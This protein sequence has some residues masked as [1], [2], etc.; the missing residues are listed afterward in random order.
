VSAPPASPKQATIL[1]VDDNDA[2]RLLAQSTLEDEDYRVVLAR[3][4]QEALETFDREQPDC[5]L[6]DAAMPDLDGFAVCTRIRASPRNADTPIVFLTAHRDLETFDRAIAAGADDF[7]TKPARPTELILRVAAAVRIRRMRTELDEH[8]VA[9][10]RQRDDLLRLHLQKERLI[11]FVVHDLKNPV[12]ALDLHAQVLLSKNLP[13]EVSSSLRAI[14]DNARQLNRMILGLLDLS[15]GDEGRLVVARTRVSSSRLV[16][17]VF[18]ELHPSAEQ[19]HIELVSELSVDHLDVDAS[20]F[21]RLL[22]NLVDNAIR[23]APRASSVQVKVGRD[24]LGVVLDVMDSGS[25]IEADQ[26]QSIF[27]AFAQADE[28]THVASRVGHGLG[29]TFCKLVAEAHGGRISVADQVDP[30]IGADFR[31]TIPDV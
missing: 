20:L 27:G 23:H 17:E 21:R 31:V 13:E 18:A 15:K 28:G 11:A 12:N 10:R 3:G 25:G 29:L 30:G 2:N 14:R 4:G 9:L 26:R 16:A 19:R 5:V 1:V 6:L 7:V 24:D 22:A 8:H